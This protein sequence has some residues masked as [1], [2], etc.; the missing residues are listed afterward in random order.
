VAL[1]SPSFTMTPQRVR[2]NL[3]DLVS[4]GAAVSVVGT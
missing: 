2:Q 1:Y 3:L 4:V